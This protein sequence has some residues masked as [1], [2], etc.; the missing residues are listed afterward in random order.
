MSAP[1]VPPT[2]SHDPPPFPSTPPEVGQRRTSSQYSSGLWSGLSRW[3][4][5]NT[6]APQWLP[7]RLRHP[8]IGYVVAALIQGAAASLILVVFSLVPDFELY[9]IFTLMGVVLV[10]LGWGAGPSLF[11]TLVSALLLDFVGGAPQFAWSISNL[12]DGIGL[13]LY[14][15]AGTSISLL[16]G[17][18]QQARRRAEETAQL[19]AQAEAR[20][21]IDADHLRTMLGALVA[22]A[23]AMVRIRPR[24]LTPTDAGEAPPVSAADTVLPVV[25]RRL[26]ELTQHV[27]GCRRVSIAAVDSATGQLRPVTEVGLSADQEQVWWASWSP[28]QRLEDRYGREIATALSAG[29]SSL[30]DTKHLPQ[31]SWYRLFGAQSGRI[32]PMQLGDELVGTLLVDYYEPNHDAPAEEILLTETLARLGALVLEQDRL[33]R[34]WAEAQANEL[35]LAETKAQMDTFLGIASHEL[36]TPLTSLKLSLQ[37]AER[38]LRK[39]TSGENGAAAGT[40]AV[41][42]QPVEEHMS[43][44]AH[45]VERMERLVNDLVDVSRIQAGK[46][47][48]RPELVDLAAMLREVVEMQE[49][50]ATEGSIRFQ[51]EADMS[52]LV[53]ADAGRIEQVVTNYL[54]NALKYSPADRPVDVGLEI[55]VESQQA[56]VWVRDQGPGLPV[57]EQERIWERF[58]RVKGIEVQSGAGVGLGLGL[59]ISRMIVERHDGQVGVES[60]VGEGSTFWFQLPLARTAPS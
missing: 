37:G 27:L 59:H 13:V 15:G 23:E 16:A 52:A 3:I 32:L 18:S 11:A 20:S 49:Q 14:L 60:V 44:T 19:L 22:T 47:E 40:D 34:G 35:A 45:Q 7:E 43:R 9:A 28:A 31:S 26:A 12:A 42:L 30:L 53:Y 33:L 2:S 48:L 8:L 50:A 21:R 54:T 10:A 6:F 5:Q 1:V 29:E 46:L 38:R 56:R 57:E 4:Q 25:A 41:L 17:W 39:L 55:E 58:H 51:C 24:T 36:K